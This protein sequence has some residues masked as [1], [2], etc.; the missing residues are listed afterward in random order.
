MRAQ[1]FPPF[2]RRLLIASL[3]LLI[4]AFAIAGLFLHSSWMIIRDARSD[5]VEAD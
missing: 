1:L 5:L 2:S 4:V 3:P